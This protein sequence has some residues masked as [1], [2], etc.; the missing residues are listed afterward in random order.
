MA[1]L[2]DLMLMIDPNAPEG[3]DEQI[4][5]DVRGMIESAGTLVGHHDW[6]SRRLAFEI[7]HRTDAAYHL[8]QFEGG[9]DLLER[10]N[11]TLKIT[12]GVL[13]FRVIRLKPG[14]PAPPTP[15]PDA[16]R[17]REGRGSDTR[18]APRSTAD[19][20]EPARN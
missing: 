9:N 17:P 1:A 20:S 14:S 3:R 2:Y 5:G 18:V 8:F 4:V 15:R 10:I 13:R 6:G 11:H 7:D 19:A 12:D 16:P